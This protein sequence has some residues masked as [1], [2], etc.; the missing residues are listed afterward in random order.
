MNTMVWS[1]LLKHTGLGDNVYVTIEEDECGELILP[2]PLE[3]CEQLGWK[4]GDTVRWH[5]NLD[6]TFSIAKVVTE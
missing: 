3:L 2:I 6:G 4:L 1:G 5:H